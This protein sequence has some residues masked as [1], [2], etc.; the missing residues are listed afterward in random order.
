MDIIDFEVLFSTL[1]V[2]ILVIYLIVPNPDI[3]FKID[4]K[5]LNI[6]VNK[7]KK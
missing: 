3:V 1:C 2:F 7:C 6:K 4:N 5:S